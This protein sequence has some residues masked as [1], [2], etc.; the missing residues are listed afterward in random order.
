MKSLIKTS[1][2]VI[3]DFGADLLMLKKY[4]EWKGNAITKE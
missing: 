4:S 3:S 1:K 2:I